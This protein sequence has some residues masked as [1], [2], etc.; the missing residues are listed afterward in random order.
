MTQKLS[1]REAEIIPEIGSP[2]SKVLRL[3]INLEI[4]SAH[5]FSYDA[6][7]VT[8]QIQLPER[9]STDKTEHLTGRTQRCSTMN[10]KA[11]FG[12]V[13]E[14][15][16]DFDLSDEFGASEAWPWIF[17]SV[18]SLDSWTRYRIEGYASLP[19][20][21]DPGSHNVDLQ[22][23]RPVGDFLNTLRRFFTGGTYEL[24]DIS[25]CG[26]PGT[27][28]GSKLVKNNL[29]TAPSGQV[30][31]KLNVAQQSRYFLQGNF[32][33][34]T[35]ERLSAGRLMNSVNDVLEQFKAARERMI[36]ARIMSS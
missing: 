19:I 18:A 32:K 22:T 3:H 15:F 25:Y 5:N 11:N 33:R 2:P 28:D 4:I 20:P 6:L 31:L 10:G 8:Y 30:T 9:W 27:Q 36:R 35:F 13:A 7:F 24:E 14:F 12:Y 29:R 21:F 26:I 34:D 16:I 23:W 1:F 17:I